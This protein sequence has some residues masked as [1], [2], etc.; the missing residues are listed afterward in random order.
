MTDQASP[1]EAGVLAGL[2]KYKQGDKYRKDFPQ[3]FSQAFKDCLAT[4]MQAPDALPDAR[5]L[6]NY[7]HLPEIKGRYQ[8]KSADSRWEA[9]LLLSEAAAVASPA[10]EAAIR[11]EYLA[12]RLNTLLQTYL[13]GDLGSLEQS[14]EG[15][16][17]SLP[18][19]EEEDPEDATDSLEGMLALQD[20]DARGTPWGLPDL[21]QKLRA[22]VPGELTILGGYG[23]HGKSSLAGYL[24]LKGLKPDMGR[25]VLWL[26][27][28]G[29]TP[30]IRLRVYSI[31]LEKS[32]EEL[33]ADPKAAQEAY[34]KVLGTNQVICRGIHDMSW[35]EVEAII[36]QHKPDLC[37]IDMIDNVI[38]PPMARQDQELT[39]LYA[40]ARQLGVRLGC[41]MLVT[42]QINAR[43]PG[44]QYTM[45]PT[46]F[47]LLGSKAGK[48]GACDNIILMGYNEEY[49]N[50]RYINI[51]KTKSQRSGANLSAPLVYSFDIA[52]S[53]YV[54]I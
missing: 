46:R 42:S 15:L 8:K 14:L 11:E 19:A 22:I 10:A 1:I 17:T 25:K 9:A 3:G 36:E 12:S 34:E 44:N 4:Y 31:L 54:T 53:Q 43:Q 28:E 50:L 49:P 37:I 16:L 23:G 13:E 52:R 26:N 41:A 24:V 33:K 30:K 39:W 2:I 32:Y 47:D 21:N 38:A 5:S 29:P 27:N 18:Q 6:F 45:R 7:L 51:D 40:R 48:A 35:R 20:E